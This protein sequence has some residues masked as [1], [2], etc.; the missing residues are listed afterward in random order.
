MTHPDRPPQITTPDPP[1]PTPLA[2]EGRNCW[3]RA[4][5]ERVALLID[6]EQY[7][8]ALKTAL[9]RA[10]H[11]ILMLGWDIDSRTVL[12]RS[13]DAFRPNT[14]GG[15]LNYVVRHRRG[16]H[17]HVLIWDTA[18]VYSWDRE[19]LTWAK[20]RWLTPRRLDY[21]LDNN[22]PIGACHH[23][24]IVVIDDRLA[25]VGGF[26]VSSGRWDTR[27]HRLVEPRRSDPA[28]QKYAPFHDA[29]LMLSGEAAAALAEVV[30]QRWRNA[31]GRQLRPVPPGDGDPW[32]PAVVPLMRGVTVA[33]ARTLPAWEGEPAVREVERLYLDMACTAKRF[34]YVENQYFASRTV[35]RALLSRLQEETPP[36]VVV[37]SCQEPVAILERTTMGAGRARLYD[38]L[39]RG[40]H[41]GRLRMYYPVTDGMEVKIHTKLAVVDDTMLRVGSANLN[42]RSMGLDTECDVLI[43]ALGDPAVEA[44]IR[45]VRCDL[46]AEHLGTTAE[47]VERATAILGL[48]DGVES[49]R[50]AVRT[51]VPVA[52]PLPEG[53]SDFAIMADLFDPDQPFEAALVDQAEPQGARAMPSRF[54]R[55]VL[56]L[57]ALLLASSLLALGWLVVPAEMELL[58]EPVRDWLHWAVKTPQG[59]LAAALTFVAAGLLNLPASALLIGCGALFGLGYG[60]AVGLAGVL[61]SG[62]ATYAA[63][64]LAGRDFVRRIAGR[65]MPRVVRALPRH[66]VFVVA[67][68][69]LVPVASYSVINLVAGAARM[70]LA[71]YLAGTVLGM[72]PVAGAMVLFGDRL[73][74]VAWRGSIL[75]LVVLCLLI[76]ALVTIE[77]S[78]ARRLARGAAAI[79]EQEVRRV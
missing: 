30:R 78:L 12:D 33:I 36:D 29:M 4:P 13:D 66:G 53:W 32:P 15:V 42:N 3:R 49:L 21:R 18:L 79:P 77:G 19:F 43:E 67:L 11:S 46:L 64:R 50:G 71:N 56:A 35:S 1:L 6:A 57:A 39:R 2:V 75:D 61:A 34:I 22:H 25:F 55:A 45:R 9:L 38:R 26:D 62:L 52:A 69:R 44:A 65:G 8:A 70:R 72:A 37:M 27:D 23:Q 20:F 59:M 73:A 17:A 47:A 28:A 74:A 7:F 60:F 48:T 54:D 10:R 5:A 24:K 68:L 58:V 31:T 41:L 51:L 40:D 16:L 14:I 76:V 63:G